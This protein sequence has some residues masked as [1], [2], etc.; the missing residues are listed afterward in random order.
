MECL[1]RKGIEVSNRY[2]AFREGRETGQALMHKVLGHRLAGTEDAF[3]LGMR[4][5][6]EQNLVL[7]KETFNVKAE[8]EAEAGRGQEGRQE[9]EAEAP[10]PNG[11]GVARRP[12][13]GETA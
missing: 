8:A 12:E 11:S 4:H 2:A 1:T 7:E 3:M 10:G 13:D 5:M 6:K 9:G